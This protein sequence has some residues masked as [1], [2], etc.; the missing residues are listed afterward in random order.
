MAMTKMGPGD[1]APNRQT[2]EN[3]S[4][5]VKLIKGKEMSD[6]LIRKKYGRLQNYLKHS[7]KTILRAVGVKKKKISG[8]WT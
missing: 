4:Q 1:M 6:Y 7:G 2:A 8:F 5:A 3:G